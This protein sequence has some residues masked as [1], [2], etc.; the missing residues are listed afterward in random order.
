MSAIIGIV[1][2]SSYFRARITPCSHTNMKPSH[3]YLEL[4]SRSRAEVMDL[5]LAG[6]RGVHGQ[7]DPVRKLGVLLAV[8]GNNRTFMLCTTYWRRPSLNL[9]NRDILLNANHHCRT[10]ICRQNPYF[11]YRH[12]R[13][14]FFVRKSSIDVVHPAPSDSRCCSRVRFCSSFSSWTTTKSPIQVVQ[15]LSKSSTYW[16][17]QSRNCTTMSEQFCEE[18]PTFCAPPQMQI[19]PE[20]SNEQRLLRHC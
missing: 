16:K 6:V 19:Y 14:Q 10:S 17:M 9:E 4:V 7:L 1:Q 11:P 13:G 8:P 18:N 12:I 15:T 20:T 5:D 3:P 2:R